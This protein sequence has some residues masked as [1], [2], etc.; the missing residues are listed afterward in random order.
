MGVVTTMENAATSHD[1]ESLYHRMLQHAQERIPCRAMD[2]ELWF[3]TDFAQQ[4]TA[5]TYCARC[6]VWAECRSAGRLLQATHGVWGGE[7]P[8]ERRR[9]GYIG[10]T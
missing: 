8:R 3:T 2:P 5:A 6:P 10:R 4:Q 1:V 7:S 9:A